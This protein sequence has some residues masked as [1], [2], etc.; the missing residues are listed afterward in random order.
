VC[1]GGSACDR[2]EIAGR[3]RSRTDESGGFGIRLSLEYTVRDTW[4]DGGHRWRRSP[5]PGVGPVPLLCGRHEWL[6]TP[7]PRAPGNSRS[8]VPVPASGG[9]LR[10]HVGLLA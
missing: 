1:M 10:V 3:K 4:P 8:P 7:K 2:G 5:Y 6:Q 9:E